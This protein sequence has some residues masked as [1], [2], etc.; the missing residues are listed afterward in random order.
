MPLLTI[1]DVARHFGGVRAIDGV[2]LELFEG[3]CLGLIGPNGAGKSTLFRLLAGLLD[4]DRGTILFGGVNLSRLSP[5]ERYRAGLAWS[6]QHPRCFPT[7]TLRQHME[8]GL[9]HSASKASPNQE[10]AERGLAAVGLLDRADCHAAELSLA[11]RK[12]L[13]FARAACADPQVLLLDEPFASLSGEQSQRIV[14]AI[15]VAKRRGTTVLVVE[16]RLPELF[17][18]VDELA[19]LANGEII[20]RG[21]PQEALETPI[22]LKAYFGVEK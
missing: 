9:L 12:L 22:V 3:Q 5:E 15:R 4:A 7:L 19:V 8:I 10:S 11:E 6:F 14:D 20:Y 1:S 21:P 18:L 13:D 16:H 2:N 17:N